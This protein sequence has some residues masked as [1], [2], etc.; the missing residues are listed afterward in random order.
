MRAVSTYEKDIL[1]VIQGHPGV[2]LVSTEFEGNDATVIAVITSDGDDSIVTPVA[3][4]IDAEDS[5]GIFD[6]LA[7][8]EKD[9]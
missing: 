5:L 2:A 8:P 1:A 7:D 4:L 9:L 6:R 3:L